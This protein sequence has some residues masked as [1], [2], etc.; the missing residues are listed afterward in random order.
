MLTRE[1][2]ANAKNALQIYCLISNAIKK[3]PRM[4][5]DYM[6]VG[7]TVNIL[8]LHHFHFVMKSICVES[9]KKTERY[10][11]SKN[12]TESVVCHHEQQLRQKEKKKRITLNR[13]YAALTNVYLVMNAYNLMNV[14]T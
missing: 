13:N 7:E 4:Q 10:L 11:N 9:E 1:K 14:I 8:Q 2:K 6:L 12:D 3:N 5:F